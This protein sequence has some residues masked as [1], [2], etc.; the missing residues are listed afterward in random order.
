MLCGSH[1]IQS[2]SPMRSALA[3]TL[4]RT[5]SGECAT[6]TWAI[7]ARTRS[8]TAASS[9]SAAMR[10][11]ERSRTAT[12]SAGTL[13]WLRMNRRSAPAQSGSRSST[14]LVSG[15]TSR[16]ASA[17]VPVANRT[18]R[19]SPSAGVRSHSRPAT[20]SDGRLPGSGP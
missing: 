3:Q 16:S 8:R 10:V 14:G 6:A 9:P 4:I 18:L 7:S 1:L 13:E 12:G 5:S 17:W 19:K 11:N 2:H 20:T 15:G